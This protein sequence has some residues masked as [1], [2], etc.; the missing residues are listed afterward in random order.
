[1]AGYPNPASLGIDAGCA[2][3]HYLN[4][5]GVTSIT[6]V[7]DKASYDELRTAMGHIGLSE[8]DREHVCKLLAS[9]LHI[10]NIRF[11]GEDEAAIL[12][13]LPVVCGTL[14]SLLDKVDLD[15]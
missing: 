9:L 3:F 7:D 14:L 15:A 11:T 12:L 1:M 13:N 8:E 2:A 5:S 6:G 4:Q 10:G